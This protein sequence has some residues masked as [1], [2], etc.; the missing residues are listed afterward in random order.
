MTGK[1]DVR[2]GIPIGTA[3]VIATAIGIKI[4]IE[5]GM[6]EDIE[7][8]MTRTP[9]AI[10]LEG[11]L[12]DMEQVRVNVTVSVI[13]GGALPVMAHAVTRAEV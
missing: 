9:G 13:M 2:R 1:L 10:T 11:A 5:T 6:I 4:E 8:P 7:G 12:E 3:T